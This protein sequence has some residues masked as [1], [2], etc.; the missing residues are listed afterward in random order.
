[1]AYKLTCA[2][3]EFLASCPN[4]SC[5]PKKFISCEDPTKIKY[6]SC[7][8]FKTNAE[9]SAY[10]DANA[11]NIPLLSQ[12]LAVAQGGYI[13]GSKQAK[14]AS[15]LIKRHQN[16]PLYED[17]VID[18]KATYTAMFGIAYDD[19]QFD[20][21]NSLETVEYTY[22]GKSCQNVS[23]AEI[24][25]K[26]SIPT[27]ATSE[28]YFYELCQQKQ[29]AN[30]L[31]NWFK[32][33]V[34]EADLLLG[35]LVARSNPDVAEKLQ[36]FKANLKKIDAASAACN[37][38][39]ITKVEVSKPETVAP[40]SP[41]EPTNA[42]ETIET[43]Y[44]GESSP[45]SAGQGWDITQSK[46]ENSTT[47]PASGQYHIRATLYNANYW[48]AAAYVIDNWMAKD[49]HSFQK[50]RFK[51]KSNKNTTFKL[52]FV[53]MDNNLES[54]HLEF[55]AST[56]Y[57]SFEFDLSAA[58]TDEYD[59]TQVQGIVIA[60]SQPGKSTYLIDLDD[61]EMIRAQGG[62]EDSLESNL[63][64]SLGNDSIRFSDNFVQVQAQ[65]KELFLVVSLA[66]RMETL[67]YRLN[68][69]TLEIFENKTKYMSAPELR[70]AAKDDGL[71]KELAQLMRS[72][73]SYLESSGEEGKIL[74]AYLEARL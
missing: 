66:R 30:S 63:I 53:S 64:K 39:R 1:V 37:N 45:F 41:A 62:Q 7:Q 17:V 21:D 54:K 55:Q 52:F 69:N 40:P 14:L 34:E 15:C 29:T 43:I 5:Q 47:S 59:L 49:F 18:L 32:F 48:G 12:Q 35:D 60:V 51:A 68:L 38:C 25:T 57:Q 16:D 73:A 24:S 8:L 56:E 13:F 67:E 58:I 3:S 65:I 74:G 61:I 42:K 33:Q 28:R 10:I 11:A 22:Q 36:S 20:C 46:V 26:L 2:R 27:L 6:K 19:S 31:T 71:Y 44:N 50:I 23:A 72:A 9:I 4:T 70:K